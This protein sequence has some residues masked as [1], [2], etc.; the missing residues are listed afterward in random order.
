AAAAV[1]VVGWRVDL[2]GSG[3]QAGRA[4]GDGQSRLRELQA[5]LQL[6][7][8]CAIVP[9]GEAKLVPTHPADGRTGEVAGGPR[10]AVNKS[11]SAAHNSLGIQLVGDPDAR[12][13]GQRIA[14]GEIAVASS[15]SGAL[16]GGAAQQPSG[17]R[18]RN[19]GPE[20]GEAVVH[21][22]GSGL[23]VPAR[24]VIQRELAGD[25]PGIVSR[26]APGA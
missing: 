24:A 18:V 3:K 17:R 1:D 15:P 7:R 22:F 14:G 19:R 9:G 6:Y 26:Q 21:L 25:L 11:P 13:D 12:A 16:V 23:V 4:R 2:A 8:R 5:I 20:H 10:R